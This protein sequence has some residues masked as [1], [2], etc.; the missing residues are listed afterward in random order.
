LLPIGFACLGGYYIMLSVATR[1]GA[2][3]D[4]ASTRLSQGLTGPVS[5][6]VLGVF[7][8]GSSGLA[9]GYVIGQSSGTSLLIKRAISGSWV[10]IGH[11]SFRGMAAV[12]TRYRHF[13][14]YATWA[15]LLDMAGSGTILFVLYSVLYSGEIA[16]YMFLAERVIARPLLIVSTSL[17]QVFTGEAGH[18]IRN[19]PARLHRRF[20]QIMPVQFM[21]ASTWIILA[22]A[23]ADWAF[24]L[25]FG[26]RWLA[27]V[28]YV[29]ASSI[30]YL[31]LTVLHPVSTSLQ[32]LERQ[33]MAVIWQIARLVL[34]GGSV[35]VAWHTGLSALT[36]LWMS[37]V[38]QLISCAT[39]L[40]LIAMTIERIQRP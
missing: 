30:A 36:A 19:D 3:Q 35:I 18:A 39:I 13:P 23:L 9:I 14:L 12:V 20:R 40:V 10:H 11:V 25:L 31:A 5:Q 34:V 27:A 37:S 8:L 28:P 33:R 4:I 7:G 17:L 1:L 16:G 26:E 22:N 32:L 6:I 15:R 29:R 21:L 24:P 2:F 38:A